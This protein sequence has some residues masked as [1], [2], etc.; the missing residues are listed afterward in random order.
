[1]RLNE[2]A[3]L[4]RK[5]P[6]VSLSDIRISIPGLRQET[7]SRWKRDGKVIMVAP[8]YYILAGEARDEID[9]YAIANRIYTPSYVSME[10]ALSY[11]GIIPDTVL[12]VTSVCTRKTRKIVSPLCLFSFRSIQPDYFFGYRVVHGVRN[13]CMMASPEKAIVDFL[14]FRRDVC[15]EDNMRELRFDGEVFA[16]LHREEMLSMSERFRKNWLNG[17]LA[18][19]IGVMKNA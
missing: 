11:H 6:V 14:Y 19:L 4:A 17:R 18:A 16:D 9:V 13:K 7:I 3:D 8:G 2:F 1:M 5:L 15:T 10:S 12:A